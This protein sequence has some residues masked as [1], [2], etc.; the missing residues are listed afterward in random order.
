MFRLNTKLLY[1]T[2]PLSCP[3]IVYLVCFLVMYITSEYRNVENDLRRTLRYGMQGLFYLPVILGAVVAL[4]DCMLHTHKRSIA[5]MFYL[6][7]AASIAWGWI[8]GA[9]LVYF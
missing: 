5:I 4:L 9:M 8:A 6:A 3:A 7:V 2:A 1:R